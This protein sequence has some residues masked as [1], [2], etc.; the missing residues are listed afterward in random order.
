MIEAVEGWQVGTLEGKAYEWGRRFG[1][2]WEGKQLPRL[3]ELKAYRDEVK[4]RFLAYFD[5]LAPDSLS[6]SFKVFGG[7]DEVPAWWVFGHLLEHFSLHRGQI[8][9]MLRMMGKEPRPA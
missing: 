7:D 5:P 3:P 8:R 2:W 9:L 4:E 6:E 1:G